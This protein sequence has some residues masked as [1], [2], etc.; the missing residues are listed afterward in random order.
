MDGHVSAANQVEWLG[1]TYKT[2]LSPDH[3]GGAMSIIDSVSPAHSGPPLH[4]HSGEDE[5][6]VVL[7]GEMQVFCDGKISAAGPGQAIFLPRGKEHSF[8]VVGD[9]PCRHLVILTP[10]GFE[11]F[12]TQMAQNRCRIPEDMNQIASTAET[13]NLAFTGPPLGA[14]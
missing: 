12:F 11:G 1:A 2:I 3:T 8:R 5:I 6:F 4:V 10:G 7:S 9:M 14:E 13:Y